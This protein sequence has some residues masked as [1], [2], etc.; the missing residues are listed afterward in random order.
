[1][2]YWSTSALNGGPV[3]ITYENGQITL[4]PTIEELVR[5]LRSPSIEEL[6]MKKFQHTVLEEVDNE[7]PFR[8]LN[9]M[10]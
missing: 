1:M 5:I 4:V 9:V 10:A 2:C 3:F 6:Y 8:H 7:I